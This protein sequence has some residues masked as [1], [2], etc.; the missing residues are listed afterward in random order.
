MA[1]RLGSYIRRNHLGLIAIFIALGGT[2]YAATRVTSDDIAKNAV[3]SKHIKEKQVKP[4]DV[5]PK[6]RDAC[7][8]TTTE[9]GPICVRHVADDLDW[10]DA[11]QACSVRSLRLPTV[12]EAYELAVNHDVP[13]V[14]AGFGFWTD[15]L[16][17]DATAITASE[18]TG[19]GGV[20]EVG[21]LETAICVAEPREGG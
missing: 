18:D 2:T 3:R 6:L 21:V 20:A 11:H 4:G 13:G 15:E 8:A 14:T 17:G 10:E 16:A 5:S 19:V 12:G 1:T 9:L 7:P